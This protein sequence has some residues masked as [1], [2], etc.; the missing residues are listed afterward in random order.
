MYV[1]YGREHKGLEIDYAITMANLAYSKFM[2]EFFSNVNVETMWPLA[3]SL[4]R[5]NKVSPQALQMFTDALAIC[6]QIGYNGPAVAKI[7]NQEVEC[8]MYLRQR[9]YDAAVDEKTVISAKLNQAFGNLKANNLTDDHPEYA[10]SI[11]LLALYN[12]MDLNN[13]GQENTELRD[14]TGKQFIKVLHA[15]GKVYGVQ[16]PKYAKAIAYHTY[17]LPRRDRD[18]IVKG[19]VAALELA[20][21]YYGE[22]HIEVLVYIY[23]VIDSLAYVNTATTMYR[24]VPGLLEKSNEIRK[25]YGIKEEKVPVW[26]PSPY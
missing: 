23:I 18:E 22:L 25:R 19:T 7:I 4:W 17:A 3:S 15:F 14:Q 8:R 10:Q 12:C 5:F 6:A 26:T 1:I 13:K 21:Q 20:K 11:M 9:T 24:K 2:L 16:H